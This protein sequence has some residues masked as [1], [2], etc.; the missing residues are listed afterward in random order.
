MPLL[1]ITMP[2]AV[3]PMAPGVELNLGNSLIPVTGMVLLL[4]DLLEGADWQSLHY[5]P[6]VVVAV[7][8]A[9][10]LVSIRWAVDQ[11]NSESVLFREGEQFELGLWFRRLMRDR[12]PTPSIAAALLCGVLILVIRFYMSSAAR[13]PGDF[14][15]FAKLTLLT[16]LAVVAAPALV[17]TV[18]LTSRPR[19]TLILRRPPWLATPAALLLAVTLHPAAKALQEVVARLYPVSEEIEQALRPIDEMFRAAP[20]WPMV[21]VLALTPAICEE[22]AFR[23]FILSGFRRLGHKWRAIIYT[24]VFFGLAHAIWQQILIACLVG[25]VIGYVAVQ[26]GSLL[27][28]VAFHLVH[29]TLLLATT[30]V[31]PELLHRWP[32]LGVLMRRTPDGGYTYPWP[33]AVA[34]GLVAALLLLWFRRLAYHKSDEERL[35]EAIERGL[36]SDHQ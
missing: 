3:L 15:G 5:L 24:A 16:Q 32:I 22:L 23:G 30:R 19:E 28:G 31:T 29:N 12:Q 11:F 20:F 13:P 8:L 27:P 1:L 18:L 6:L 7:T 26:S 21:L 2:L 25:V 36:G 4:R 34:G 9:V 33:A 17:M 14:G 10:C 35:Q